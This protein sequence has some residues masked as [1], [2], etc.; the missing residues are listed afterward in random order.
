MMTVMSHRGIIRSLIWCLLSFPVSFA[1]RLSLD[2]KAPQFAR[3]SGGLILK[4]PFEAA[5]R[6]TGPALST[7]TVSE[8]NIQ[9]QEI[10]TFKLVDGELVRVVEGSYS[11]TSPEGIPVSVNYVADENGYRAG[12]RLGRAALS[13]GMMGSRI[14]P[15]GP[16]IGFPGSNI[17]PHGSGGTTYLPPKPKVDRSY[18]PPQ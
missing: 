8:G 5:Q 4:P 3:G 13:G 2:Q 12:F 6:T 10:A 11:Y 15:S 9:R 14:T 18:L 17:K 1:E 16:S 7:N